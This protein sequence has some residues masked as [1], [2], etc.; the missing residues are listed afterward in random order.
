MKK[1]LSRNDDI[2]DMLDN[3]IAEIIDSAGVLSLSAKP[4]HVLMWSHY[5]DSHR[6]ICLRFRASSTTPFFGRA[7]RVVYQVQRPALNVMHDTPHIQ[8]EKALLT[9]ADFWS[10][11]EEW[12][13]VEHDGGPGIHKFPRELLDTVILGAHISPEDQGKVLKW[14]E[15]RT[16]ETNVLQ[17]QVDAKNFRLR[18]S[19]T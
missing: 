19:N 18:I 2:K 17:T 6:G 9:K 10:Y 1:N 3:A 8:S 16:T 5:A 4:D 7:Q 12:R 15:Q 13:I 14:I 11:E